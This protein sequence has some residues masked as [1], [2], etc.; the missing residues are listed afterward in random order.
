MSHY[1][2]TCVVLV[3][4]IFTTFSADHSDPNYTLHQMIYELFPQPYFLLYMAAL[5]TLTT[6]LGVGIVSARKSLKDNVNC[7]K[8]LKYLAFAYA[9]LSGVFGSLSVLSGKI[10][11]SIIK[12]IYLG[13]LDVLRHLATYVAVAILGITVFSQTHFMNLVCKFIL[14]AST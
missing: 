5:A 9:A 6:V 10:M 4:A 14:S 11:A 12:Q 8:S 1:A 7:S 3:G 2:A 13:D